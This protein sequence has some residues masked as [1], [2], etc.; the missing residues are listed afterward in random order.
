[1]AKDETTRFARRRQRGGNVDAPGFGV[2]T[3]LIDLWPQLMPTVRKG[4]PGT[5]VSRDDVLREDVAARSI[6]L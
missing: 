5:I 6:G 2:K 4:I 1:M 3:G